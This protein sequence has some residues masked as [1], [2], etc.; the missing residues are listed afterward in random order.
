MSSR[1]EPPHAGGDTR[2]LRLRIEA[3]AFSLRLQSPLAFATDCN[4]QV[5]VIQTGCFALAIRF[6]LSACVAL[7][8]L[9]AAWAEKESKAGGTKAEGSQP[10]IH[11]APRENLESVDAREIGRAQLSIDIAAYVLSDPR[12]I[13]ALTDAAERG[14]LIR[15]YLD[16]SQFAEHG[17][18]RA[19]LVEALLARPNVVARVKGEGVLM[20]LKAYA[21]DGAVLRTGS[22][23]FSRSGLAA[24]DNDA[25]FITDPAVVDAF[26]SNF[27]RIWA[28]AQNIGALDA[29]R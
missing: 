6:F 5:V 20:H 26:E 17:P 13:E 19:G 21:V 18:T 16:K 4:Y 7:A 27:E 8:A 14:V 22:G 29:T 23:N 2:A 9:G 12:I 3:L 24:Q 15:L 11:Y 10:E 1:F 28:R 25:I